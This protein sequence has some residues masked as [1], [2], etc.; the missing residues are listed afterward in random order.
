MGAEPR[1]DWNLAIHHAPEGAAA[2]V[3]VPLAPTKK[4]RMGKMLLVH[5][6]GSE[7]LI[8]HSGG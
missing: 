5:P 6:S 7:G 4:S 3:V 1:H 2:Q 8:F